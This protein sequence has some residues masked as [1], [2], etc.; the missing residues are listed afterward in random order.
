MVQGEGRVQVRRGRDYD[1]ADHGDY[2][3]DQQKD[4]RLRAEWALKKA[5]PSCD[6][7]PDHPCKFTDPDNDFELFGF[8]PRRVP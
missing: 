1:P 7:P 8:H 2:L 5:C 6:A 4:D 3:R